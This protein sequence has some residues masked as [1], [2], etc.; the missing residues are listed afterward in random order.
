MALLSSNTTPSGAAIGYQG[1]RISA[2][3]DGLGWAVCCLSWG[4][5]FFDR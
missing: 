2:V 3:W 5:T 4:S 1:I